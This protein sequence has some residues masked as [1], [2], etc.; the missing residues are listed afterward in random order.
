M[1]YDTL[2]LGAGASGLACARKLVSSHK[3]LVLEAR[4]RIGGRILTHRSSQYPVPVDLG[5]E[6][7][8][9][10]P[11]ETFELLEESG[12]IAYDQTFRHFESNN[13]KP[14]NRDRLWTRVEKLLDR[15]KCVGKQDCSFK[16]FIDAQRN[17]P[18]DVRERAVR[19]IESFN[20]ARQERI[21]VKSLV[22]SSDEE[23]KLGDTQYRLVGGHDQLAAGLARGMEERIAL[24]TVVTVVRWSKGRVEVVADTLGGER[25]FRARRVVITLPLG[26]LQSDAVRFEPELP[27]RRLIREQL[28]MGHVIKVTLRCR[29]AFWEALD[30][31]LAFVHALGSPIPVWWTTHPL[32][33]TLFTGWVGGAIA[34]T[35]DITRFREAVAESLSRVFR[36]SLR[37]IADQV[38]AIH[39]HDWSRD[40]FSRGAYSYA[41]VGGSGAPERLSRPLAGTLYFAGEHT[42][43][44]LMGTVAGAIQTG[45]HAAELILHRRR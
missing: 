27:V 8:H 45:Y 3:I 37:E 19:Y 14:V 41:A 16:D 22:I 13:G 42:H 24:N 18:P 20:A 44:G 36:R 6:F 2:I 12:L 29:T 15:M 21:S 23:E 26:V 1:T 33:T 30:P 10:H 11:R 39:T 17:V 4:N 31:N 40:P 35:F 43:T 28:C 5:P 25:T 34:E 7:I 32:R 9:G 38:L